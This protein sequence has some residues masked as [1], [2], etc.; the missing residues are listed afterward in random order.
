MNC[1]VELSYE[2]LQI[3]MQCIQ[4]LNFE[5]KHVIKVGLL[6]HKLQTQIVTIEEKV[7][8]NEQQTK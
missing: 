6:G 7:K 8:K 1:K 2:E 3:L 5:G 4:S